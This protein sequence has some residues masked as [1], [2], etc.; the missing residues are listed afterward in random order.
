[1]V[2]IS[3]V[4]VSVLFTIVTKPQ[5]QCA[6]L[7]REFGGRNKSSNRNRK[8]H[9]A[10]KRETTEKRTEIHPQNYDEEKT[11]NIITQLCI[12]VSSRWHFIFCILHLNDM[13]S[14][15]QTTRYQFDLEPSIQRI[16][17]LFWANSNRYRAPF[18]C[19]NQFSSILFLIMAY[20]Y[21]RAG[22]GCIVRCTC[23]LNGIYVCIL[24]WILEEN[25]AKCI[26][27]IT[28]VSYILV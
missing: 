20:F 23:I 11:Q 6:I 22:D 24:N 17:L 8:N 16:C 26:T 15:V 19:L 7:R 3:T 4:A 18:A 5:C 27:L 14:E 25:V 10:E 21:G 12:S 13:S 1:M 28:F 2:A 9:L